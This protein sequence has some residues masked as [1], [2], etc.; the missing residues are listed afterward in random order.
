[1]YLSAFKL[2][3]AL[4]C[5]K[6]FAFHQIAKV[7]FKKK[8]QFCW[9]WSKLGFEKKF[10]SIFFIFTSV[11]RWFH[12]IFRNDIFRK[13]QF[14][15]MLLFCD[16]CAGSFSLLALL[17][18]WDSKMNR[19]LKP[20]EFFPLWRINKTLALK[21]L[22]EWNGFRCQTN[23]KFFVQICCQIWN[24]VWNAENEF[25]NLHSGKRFLLNSDGG[26]KIEWNYCRSS[27]ILKSYIDSIRT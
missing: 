17:S 8:S 1:M 15:C 10:L 21:I 22:D 25:L 4:K 19:L 3:I 27:I 20:W 26:K 14:E 24:E 7:L 9:S 23:F 13:T 11:L 12:Q 5:K 2:D 18:I 6:N 16:F